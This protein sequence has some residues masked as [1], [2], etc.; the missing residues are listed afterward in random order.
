MA[1]FFYQGHGSLRFQTD[2]GTVIYLDPFAGEGYDLPADLIL[3]THGHHDHNVV[4]LPATQKDCAVITH[5]DS[6]K[7][8]E[9]HRFSVKDVE[10]E[11]VPAYN[12]HHD[13]AECVGY[14][15]RFDGLTVYASGDTSTTDW[16]K[17]TAPGLGIDY[18]FY[19]ID[20]IY[21]MDAAEA[22]ACAAAVGARH[23]IPIHMKPGELFDRRAAEAFQASGR[24]IVAAG[25]ELSL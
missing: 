3:V 4:S 16:M 13:R 14:L 10:V 11:A 24:I 17:E 21:N 19:P 20:G 5:E 1:K 8:G 7:G 18:A 9:Y 23:S 25:E 15:L 22:S 6:L 2:G 12:S